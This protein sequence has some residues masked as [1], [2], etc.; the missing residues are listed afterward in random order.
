MAEQ[1]VTGAAIVM[2]GGVEVEAIG[3]AAEIMVVEE[4]EATAM[5]AE[6]EEIGMLTVT[7]K[8]LLEGTVEV[9]AMAA[10]VGI[11][12]AAEV[13][14]TAIV[15]EAAAETAMAAEVV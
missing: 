15:E 3:S 7:V 6:A 8:V 14:E 11:A 9:I 10:E 2:G 5:A 12:M 13:A 4:V 1:I